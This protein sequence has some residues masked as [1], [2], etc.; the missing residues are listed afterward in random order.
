MFFV[1]TLFFTA[2]IAVPVLV[3]IYFLHQK[4]KAV[5]ISSLILWENQSKS[6]KSGTG[7]K[8]M[9]FP[10]KFFIEMIIIILLVIA[11][12]GPFLLSNEKVP[13]LTVILDDSFSMQAGDKESPREEA[14][15]N[16]LKM[17]SS[18]PARPVYLILA[19]PS[20]RLL[21]NADSDSGKIKHILKKWQCRQTS[22]DING[23]MLFAKKT[24][25]AKNDIL[26]MTDHSPPIKNL[27]PGINWFSF[28]HVRGNKAI[29]NAARTNSSQGDR[30]LVEVVNYSVQKNTTTV[31]VEFIE[32]LKPSLTFKLDVPPGKKAKKIF[33]LPSDA[34]TIKISLPPDQLEFDNE[35]VLLPEKPHKLRIKLGNINPEIRKLLDKVLNSTKGISYSNIK[36][37]LVFTDKQQKNN[38]P[39]DLW[40]III[41]QGKKN[42]AFIGPYTVDRHHPLCEGLQ[43][44]GIIWGAE[45]GAL[46]GKAL[47]L[48]GNTPLISDYYY[49]EKHYVFIKFYPEISTLQGSPNWPVLIY[50]L[51]EWRRRYLPGLSKSN[52][53]SGE[54]IKFNI[55]SKTE[56]ITIS[57]PDGN[58]FDLNSADRTCSLN[59]VLPGK[60]MLKAKGKDYSFMINPLCGDESDLRN[61]ASKI[62]EG[63]KNENI[64]RKRFQNVAWIFL[65]TALVFSVWHLYLIRRSTS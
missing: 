2:L 12:A 64:Y 51:V 6:V 57:S 7:L 4:V 18:G 16:L 65:L 63:D 29:I 47:V 61:C 46:P 1:N 52:Y 26:V 45:D 23:A 32:S 43:L 59:F 8:A 28:G 15:K 24:F 37:H 25:G 56:T 58:T 14:E 49:G 35:V 9:P 41:S 53:R 54:K 20:P 17:L 19:G 39:E 34:G 3:L 27:K 22:A 5:Q 40:Q 11:A 10:L 48:A 42:K 60:Y 21:D 33:V 55:P 44:D 31:K 62:L 36:P 38:L 13:A 30:C 50:N